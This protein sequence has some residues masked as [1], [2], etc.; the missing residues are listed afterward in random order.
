LDE[1]ILQSKDLENFLNILRSS[2]EKYNIHYENV[3]KC[4]KEQNNIVHDFELLDLK[5]SGRAKLGTKLTKLRKERRHSKD[6]VE[7]T[8]ETVQFYKDNGMF[9]KKLEKLLGDLRKKE[10]NMET[11]I[12][13]R[14]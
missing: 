7:L 5:Y 4:D 9:I 3:N 12:Y 11:R 14:R 8:S 10:K 13:I 1:N 2:Q 6:I